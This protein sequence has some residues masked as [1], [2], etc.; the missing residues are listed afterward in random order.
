MIPSLLL[1]LLLRFRFRFR[2]R[3]RL[4]VVEQVAQD[5]SDYPCPTPH[6]AQTDW[7]QKAI[8]EASCIEIAR[9]ASN[10]ALGRGRGSA[11]SVVVALIVEVLH[12]GWQC[13]FT[14]RVARRRPCR[15]S[16]GGPKRRSRS[17][18]S[19]RCERRVERGWGA[20]G[21]ANELRITEQS[22][23]MRLHAVTLAIT[24]DTGHNKRYAP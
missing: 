13:C 2:L 23:R 3:L 10:H 12:L 5:S 15:R 20:G 17:V 1:L 4:R 19:A 11:W 21:E 22:G 24:S 7:V 8:A 6:R 14:G 18:P 9:V 16:F